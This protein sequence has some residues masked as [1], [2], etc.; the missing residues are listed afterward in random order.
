MDGRVGGCRG[1]VWLWM[2]EGVVDVQCIA[3]KLCI[4]DLM[5]EGGRCGHSLRTR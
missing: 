2:R 5:K 4:K 3:A 1:I